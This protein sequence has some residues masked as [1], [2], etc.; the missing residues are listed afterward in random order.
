MDLIRLKGYAATR[1][2]DICER[3]GLSKGSFFHHFKSK[4]EL[5]VAAADYWGEVSTALF[6][7]APYHALPNP[8]ARIFAYINL[9]KTLLQGGPPNFSCLAGTMLQETYALHPEIR[10]ACGKTILNHAA[11]LESDIA[12]AMRERGIDGDWTAKSLALHTQTVLQ[13]AFILAKAQGSSAIVAES[14]DHLRRY[15][16]LLFHEN[17]Q[18]DR[19]GVKV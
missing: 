14:I 15:I 19:Q 4:E 7:N 8:L 16:E 1:V 10:D 6:G 11:G 3:A 13:G 2:E 9:R 5:A 17:A 18:P 12:E